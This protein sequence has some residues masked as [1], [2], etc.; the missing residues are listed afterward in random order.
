MQKNLNIISYSQP[1]ECCLKMKKEET[2]MLRLRRILLSIAVLCIL[3]ATAIPAQKRART[4]Q[5][6][7]VFVT[8]NGKSRRRFP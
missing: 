3:F 1:F 2:L 6:C 7:Y 8:R 5:I 4:L